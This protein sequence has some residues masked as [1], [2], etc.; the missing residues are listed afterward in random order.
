M[1]WVIITTPMSYLEHNVLKV[2]KIVHFKQNDL[3]IKIKIFCLWSLDQF[4]SNTIKYNGPQLTQPRL[5]RS[6][7]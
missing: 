6:S 1:G 2:E 5:V 3:G 7:Q 4:R